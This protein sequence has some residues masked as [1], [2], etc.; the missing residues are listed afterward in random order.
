MRASL[1]NFEVSS[2]NSWDITVTEIYIC[3]KFLLSESFI[4]TFLGLK[5]EIS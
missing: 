4:L 3:F 5:V 1:D 2:P